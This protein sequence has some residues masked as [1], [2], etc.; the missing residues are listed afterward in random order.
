MYIYIYIFQIGWLTLNNANDSKWTKITE[1]QLF[2][3]NS[4]NRTFALVTKQFPPFVNRQFHWLKEEC[5]PRGVRNRCSQQG[6][7][8]QH[9]ALF[10]WRVCCLCGHD[11]CQVGMVWQDMTRLLGTRQC[12]M[13]NRFLMLSNVL[14]HFLHLADFVCAVEP[15]RGMSERRR[16]G[17]LWSWQTSEFSPFAS[18]SL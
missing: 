12:N 8:L 13:G 14:I 11:M 5:R 2:R 17:N 16:V 15:Y 18:A 10:G 4:I 1:M 6:L 9:R 3:R 7:S